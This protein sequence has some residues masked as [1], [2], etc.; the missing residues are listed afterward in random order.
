MT[1]PGRLRAALISTAMTLAVVGWGFGGVASA[2]SIKPGQHFAGVV[3][4]RRSNAIIKVVC[5][6]PISPGETG[7]VV[8][9]QAVSV[10]KAANGRGYTGLFSQVYF[11]VNP[12][13][14]A[15][16]T[17]LT[18]TRYGSPQ[19]IPTTIRVPCGGTGQVTFSSC[20][21]LA[22]CAAGWVPESINVTFENLAV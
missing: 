1:V 5:A 9:G 11:W 19:T 20:P 14:A 13:P 3:N 16:P 22:P 8:G 6:G 7:P 12:P 10:A 18:F 15:R 4:G 21:Y 2:A 17:T